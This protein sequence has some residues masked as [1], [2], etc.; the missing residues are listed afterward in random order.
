MIE[1]PIEPG[2]TD[3]WMEE[4]HRDVFAMRFR[5]KNVLFSGKSRY[6]HVEV[7]ETEGLGRMLLNDGVIMISERDEFVYHE[8]MAHVPLFTHPAPTRVL[9]IGGG[10]G[11]TAREVLKHPGVAVCRLVEIDEMVVEA[12]KEFIPQTACSFDDPRLQLTI[13]DGV[14]FVAETDERYDVVMVDSA[15]PI[16]PAKALFGSDFY[17]NVDRV[18]AENGIVVSQGESPFYETATQRALLET[19]GGIF[20]HVHIYNFTNMTYPGGLWSFTYASKGPCPETD[21]NSDRVGDSGLAFKYYSSGV[22]RGAFALPP[23]MRED[24]AGLLSAH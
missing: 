19:L 14:R 13:A 3:L 24:L 11:G 23:F 22:H 20:P 4:R 10:D 18:L 12:C 6:Q 21:F 2:T 5:V 7:I 9:V 17:R 8:M 1:M 15:D 16:G